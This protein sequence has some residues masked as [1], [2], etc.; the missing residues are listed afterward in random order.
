MQHHK[1]SLEDIEFMV[2]YEKE[3]YVSLLL[4]YLEE[5]KER[6]RERNR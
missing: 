1:Y 3:V 2:P 5:E 4:S 6:L